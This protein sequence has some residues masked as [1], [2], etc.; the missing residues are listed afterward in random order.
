MLSRTIFM[1]DGRTITPKASHFI[2][3]I[4]VAFDDVKS[5]RS[6]NFLAGRL[7]RVDSPPGGG[8]CSRGRPEKPRRDCTPG[9]LRAQEKLRETR[10]PC[11]GICP[12]V[13]YHRPERRLPGSV[14][15]N[16]EGGS[17]KIK[18]YLGLFQLGVPYESKGV[19]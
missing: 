17:L 18:N 7:I 11:A 6:H 14:R 13:Q 15:R 19:H 16:L 2:L 1:I 9:Q 8:A 4:V 5:R 12:K 3:R 10:C